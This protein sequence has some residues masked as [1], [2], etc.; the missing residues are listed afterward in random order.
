MSIVTNVGILSRQHKLFT[1]SGP[2]SAATAG[3]LGFSGGGGGV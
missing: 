3:Y 1:A 2:A